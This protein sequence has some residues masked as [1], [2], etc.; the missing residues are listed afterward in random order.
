MPEENEH[1]ILWTQVTRGEGA[2]AGNGVPGAGRGLSDGGPEIAPP[3]R[4]PAGCSIPDCLQVPGHGHRKKETELQ[5]IYV[6][7]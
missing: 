2:G 1:G 6:Y 7:F 4:T 5:T 3:P